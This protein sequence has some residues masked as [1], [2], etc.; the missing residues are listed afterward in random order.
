MY[1]YTGRAA[2]THKTVLTAETM[3][4]EDFINLLAATY[5]YLNAVKVSFPL[6]SPEDINMQYGVDTSLFSLKGASR[7]RWFS[8]PSLFSQIPPWFPI[9]G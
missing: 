1:P 2:D 7:R 8:I 9:A 6:L 4:R 5:R 3:K